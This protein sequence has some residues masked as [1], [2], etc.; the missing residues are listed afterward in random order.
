M[1]RPSAPLGQDE[2]AIDRRIRRTATRHHGVVSRDQL[3]A[4]GCSSRSIA[5]RVERGLL[6]ELGGDVFVVGHDALSLTGW[7]HAALLSAGE[8]AALSW[9]SSAHLLELWERAPDE[10]H[11]SVPSR[12]RR[13]LCRETVLHR[14]RRPLEQGDVIRRGGLRLTSP[15]RTLEDLAPWVPPERLLVMTEVACTK[16]HVDPLV[17]AARQ[18]Q[19]GRAPGSARLERAA[20]DAAGTVVLKSTLERRFRELVAARGL[21]AYETNVMVGAW[22]IDVLWRLLGIAI[23]LDVYRWHGARTRYKRDRRKGTDLVRAGL[24]FMR[25]DG[26]DLDE[27]PDEVMEA[28]EL[29]VAAAQARLLDAR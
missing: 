4:A 13:E 1:F 17:L 11:V 12:G 23:E 2:S 28:V 9:W 27:R 29:M 8:D 15:V 5:G 21:P 3:T 7:Q 25:I 10:V 22:E 6:G 14:P 16:H 18:R 19:R 20:L 24:Q 26:D